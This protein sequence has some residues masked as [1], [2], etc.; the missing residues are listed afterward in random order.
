MNSRTTESGSSGDVKGLITPRVLGTSAAAAAPFVL[1]TFFLSSFFLSLQ[2]LQKL[3]RA[4]NGIIQ[5]R[6][7]Y[8]HWWWAQSGLPT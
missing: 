8:R 1:Y 4:V 7:F 6:A 3:R 5:F 2:E